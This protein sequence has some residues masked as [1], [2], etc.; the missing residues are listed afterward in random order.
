MEIWK[1]IEGYEGLYQV[2][3]KG[4]VKSLDRYEEYVG[5]NETVVLRKR[6]GRIMTTKKDKDGYCEVGLRKE[7]VGR[8]FFRVHRLV[9][10]AFCYN[11]SPNTKTVVN[12]INCI[13]DDNR[14]ENLEWC[15]VQYNTKYAFDCGR[16]PSVTTNLHCELLVDGISV[17]TFTNIKEASEYAQKEYGVSKSSLIKYRKSK[18]IAIKIIEKCND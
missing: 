4:R 2:S 17:K 5:R 16:K 13:K 15:T 7:S 11:D 10:E 3:N 14:A 9:A 18:N 1:D 12:H 8:K 6:K